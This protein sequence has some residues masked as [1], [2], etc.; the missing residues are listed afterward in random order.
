MKNLRS[1]RSILSFA[2]CLLSALSIVRAVVNDGTQPV[3]QYAPA[4]TTAP[5]VPSQISIGD[6]SGGDD[7]VGN[8]IFRV[9]NSEKMRIDATGKVGIGTNAAAFALDIANNESANQLRIRTTLA[10]GAPLLK[11]SGGYNGGNGAEIWQDATGIVRFNINSGFTGI[12]MAPN[13]TVAANRFT[14]NSGYETAEITAEANGTRYFELRDGATVRDFI[15]PAGT[16][17]TA[18]FSQKMGVGTPTPLEKL[19]VLGGVRVSDGANGILSLYGDSEGSKIV[20]GKLQGGNRDIRFVDRDYPTNTERELVRIKSSGSVGIGTSSPGSMLTIQGD[21]SKNIPLGIVA[22]TNRSV[23]KISGGPVIQNASM[24]D[25]W[26]LS[27]TTTNPGSLSFITADW[28]NSNGI[29]LITGD[30]IGAPVVWMYD[31]SGHNA[32]T[33]AKKGY[34][35]LG[36]DASSIDGKLTP[37]FQVRDNGNVGIG[38]VSPQAKLHVA[39]DTKIE[40]NLEVAS[41]KTKTWSIAPDYVFEKEYKLA[42]LDHVEKYLSK[43]KHLPEIPS[44]KEIKEKGLDLAEMNLKLLKKVEELTLYAIE[45]K[46]YSER[47]EKEIIGLRMAMQLQYPTSSS[48]L[49]KAKIEEVRKQGS[50]NAE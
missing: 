39:G 12:R 30:N 5:I 16:T 36:D 11:F 34:S 2:G 22:P 3:I 35:G 43:N 17:N 21:P 47:Q 7:A 18:Y 15:D 38:T 40:G 31:Y 1:I 10:G 20:S 49:N 45:Q 46:K 19:D 27:P 42:S 26:N 29:G 32:F 48:N 28:D 23:A 33:V 9:K 37:L 44:A 24:R 8:L 13:G 50:N 41:V 6:I 14:T 4:T 25:K